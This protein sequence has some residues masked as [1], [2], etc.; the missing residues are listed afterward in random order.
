MENCTVIFLLLFLC[1]HLFNCML[2][3]F[4]SLFSLFFPLK[5]SNDLLTSL[6]PPFQS[7]ESV[8]LFRFGFLLD[9]MSPVSHRVTYS[10]YA[11]RTTIIFF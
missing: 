3:L 4:H 7:I 2:L 10:G 5:T 8:M 1:F 6:F 11:G 9:E